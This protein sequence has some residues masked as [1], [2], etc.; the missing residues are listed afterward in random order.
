MSKN[1][2]VEVQIEGRTLKLTNL[3][4][5]LY[6]EVGFTKGQVIDYY[7]RM[8]P[9][10]LPHTRNHPLTLKRYPNGV[11]AEFF[12]EKN[13]P[14]HRPPWVETATVWSGGDKRS[15]YSYLCPINPPLAWLDTIVITHHHPPP[16]P[17]PQ[18][19]T[20]PQLTLILSTHQ[21]A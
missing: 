13:C 15:M 17:A 1:T 14:K 10:L 8:A 11:D 19:P 9:A 21:P 2:E 18:L 7:T 4:K 6:P 20:P 16:I 3:D 12:Y 5:V